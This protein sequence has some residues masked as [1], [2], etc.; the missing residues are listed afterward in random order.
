MGSAAYWKRVVASVSLIWALGC[1]KGQPL[2][3]HG[4]AKGEPLS[5]ATN[6]PGATDERLSPTD[7]RK[8]SRSAEASGNIAPK[9]PGKPKKAKPVSES[10][11][12]VHWFTDYAGAR[13]E[14]E[15]TDKPLFVV[16]R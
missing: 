5:S 10:E 3:D 11:P 12:V 14:A 6:A 15:R 8:A 4:T 9:K 1:G 7:T 2:N 16:F 13:Q